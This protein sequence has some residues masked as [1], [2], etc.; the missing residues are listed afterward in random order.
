MLLQEGE[1]NHNIP[2]PKM[3]I[4]VF[5]NICGWAFAFAIPIHLPPIASNGVKQL[6]FGTYFDVKDVLL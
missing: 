3:P 4:L 1:I 5:I 2:V 6:S